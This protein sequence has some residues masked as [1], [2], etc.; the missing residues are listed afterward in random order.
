MRHMLHLAGKVPDPAAGS[1]M[2]KR[3]LG[4]AAINKLKELITAQHGDARVV[5]DPRCCP[6]PLSGELW[7]Q[8]PVLCSE[9]GGEHWRERHA[10][11]AGRETKD[12]QMT[13]PP[14]SPLLK[15]P[16]MQSGRASPGGCCT[17]PPIPPRRGWSRRGGW[18]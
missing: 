6:G 1:D 12:D 16:A 9:S 3:L 10:L 13:R 8:P 7:P 5:D 17:P 14:V 4:G 11:G 2:L 15:K 18:P